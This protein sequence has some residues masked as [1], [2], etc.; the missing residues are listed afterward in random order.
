[1]ALARQIIDALAVQV[2]WVRPLLNSLRGQ[3]Q[4]E[5]E[6][7]LEK[8][9]VVFH[10]RSADRINI[11]TYQ[12]AGGTNG[13]GLTLNG[14]VIIFYHEWPDPDD[15]YVWN[16]FV[17]G[18]EM[19]IEHELAHGTQVQKSRGRLS[20]PDADDVFA[21][22]GNPTEIYAMAHSLIRELRQ[23]NY[24]D[25]A[26]LSALRNPREYGADSHTLWIYM[27]HFGTNDPVFQRLAT[28]VTRLLR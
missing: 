9:R 15:D 14:T 20:V 28:T 6:T 23:M 21:Y 13:A 18:V 11:S 12:A 25:E 4:F 19:L 27:D 2:D 17:H 7:A 5:I 22:L 3:S 26:I 16:A 10:Y 1:M 24:D 8:H